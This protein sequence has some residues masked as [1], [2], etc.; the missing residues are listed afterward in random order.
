LSWFL[1]ECLPQFVSRILLDLWV[2]YFLQ[3]SC[4]LSHMSLRFLIVSERSIVLVFFTCPCAA[5]GRQQCDYMCDC[6]RFFLSTTRINPLTVG[7]HACCTTGPWVFEIPSPSCCGQRGS[8][9]S[10]GFVSVLIHRGVSFRVLISIVVPFVL[11][12]LVPLL[13][14]TTPWSCFRTLL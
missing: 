9:S 2:S 7:F 13:I 5:G 14:I 3:Y 4:D 11:Y 6:A 8:V 12:E 10:R 1:F